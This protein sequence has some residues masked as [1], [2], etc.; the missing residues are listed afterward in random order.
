MEML[1]NANIVELD[2]GAST[3]TKPYGIITADC[4]DP[5]EIDDG[6]FVQALDADTETYR[7]GVC[8]VD[9][10]GL[11]E[12]RSLVE[13]VIEKTEARYA[14]TDS[15]GKRGYDP[16]IPIEAI[17]ELEFTAGSVRDALIVSFTVGKEQ[18]PT[19]LDVSFGNI[20]V[21][22][23]YT[24]KRF[25]TECRYSPT[26]HRFGRASTF[27]QQHL[28]YQ[29]GGDEDGAQQPRVDT[30]DLYNRLI[31]VPKEKVW[32]RGAMLNE[33]FMVAAGHL[34]GRQLAAEGGLAIYRV[35]DPENDTFNV[36]LPPEY[37]HYSWE[38]GV[39]AGL[40]LTPFC[41]VTSPLRRAEDFMMSHHLRQRDLGITPT[42]QDRKDNEQA[43][44]SLNHRVMEISTVGVK[45]Y[46]GL[47]Q[48]GK[49]AVA[50]LHAVEELQPTG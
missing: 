15:K 25:G 29:P 43:V 16:M 6:L 35:F 7:V 3:D 33:A 37:A 45:R 22:R 23:N 14:G 40:N 19:D 12:D 2:P 42:K 5:K 41:R 4:S 28:R 1:A 47:R 31:H 30:E 17:H 34:V 50:S 18:A 32:R 36:F 21:R 13:R 39:H 26:H 8:V 44:R 11:Y 48:T 49:L 24:Y 9:T 27:V 46:Y 10:S 38:P 20:E